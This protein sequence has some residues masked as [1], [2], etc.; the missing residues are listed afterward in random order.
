VELEKGMEGYRLPDPPDD[1]REPM[2]ASL[3]FLDVALREMT[4]PLWA[5]VYLAPLGEALTTDFCLWLHGPTGARKSTTAALALCHY[6]TF[7]RTSLPANFTSTGYAMVLQTFA[8][9]DA[10]LVVDDYNPAADAKTAAGQDAAAHRLLRAAGDR[11]GRRQGTPDGR[12]REDKPPRCLPVITA[13]LPPPGSQSSAARAFEVEW[14]PGAVDAGK[15]TPAQGEAAK[16]AQAMAA[17]L[18]WLAPQWEGWRG[19]LTE[20][21]RSLRS[22]FEA[23]GVTHGRV[24]ESAAKLLVGAETALRFAEEVG[25]LTAEEKET[26]RAGARAAIEAQALRSARAQAER[27]P[28]VVF[29]E[30]LS[31]MLAQGLVYL[32]NRKTGQAPSDAKAWGYGGVNTKDGLFYQPR[33]G[34]VKLGWVD[35]E[36][37]EVYL[38][39]TAAHR[40]V[41]RYAREANERF[42]CG[43]RALGEHLEREGLL[44]QRQGERREWAIRAEGQTRWVWCLEA[45]S[46]PHP[47]E[48]EILET[49]ETQSPE[50]PSSGHSQEAASVSTSPSTG[51]GNGNG[52]GNTAAGAELHNDAGSQEAVS[53]VSTVSIST[54]PAT[55]VVVKEGEEDLPS[56]A[57][58]LLRD[59]EREVFEL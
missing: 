8:A 28:T 45:K 14:R 25:A 11:H 16:Y 1:L 46:L 20:R 33:P 10:L 55:E 4:W 37:E 3:A 26:Y 27:K 42:P 29:L 2:R 15:L 53:S 44:A 54:T 35:T 50:T 6:G 24:A 56:L 40:E 49:T 57:D 51:N 43:K 38:L 39:P 58:D 52:N 30:Y 17:Y 13:E 41:T 21:M 18:R 47:A 19:T 7:E 34:A 48:M 32:A 9:K 22:E 31:T 5:A 36:K 59:D 12:L 23:A